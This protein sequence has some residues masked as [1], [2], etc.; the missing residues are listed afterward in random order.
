MIKI[1]WMSCNPTEL[2]PWHSSRQHL[3]S[4]RKLEFTPLG[5]GIETAV[6]KLPH[7]YSHREMSLSSLSLNISKMA[8]RN[9][10][11]LSLESDVRWNLQS[12]HLLLIKSDRVLANVPCYT[13]PASSACRH[14]SFAQTLLLT[15]Q[16]R[17]RWSHDPSDIL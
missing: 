6:A 2:C 15:D 7:R 3:T 8:H 10:A 5:S 1:I 4:G 17:A 11:L 13:C 12:N 14:R 16:G 9:S